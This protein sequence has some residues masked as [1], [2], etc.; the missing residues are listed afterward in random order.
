MSDE[1]KPQEYTERKQFEKEA[2]DKGFTYVGK[3]LVNRESEMKAAGEIQYIDDLRMH[4]MLHGKILFSP[5]AHAKIFAI[6]TSKA[7]ALCQ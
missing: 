5:H 6:D 7:E 3:P 1:K 4:G 2:A